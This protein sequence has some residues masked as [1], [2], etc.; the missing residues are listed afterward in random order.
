MSRKFSREVEARLD[1]ELTPKKGKQ[2]DPS[3]KKPTNSPRP[4]ASTNAPFDED[5]IFVTVPIPRKAANQ[6]LKAAGLPPGDGAE[7]IAKVS[8]FK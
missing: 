3:P 7:L 8:T 4:Q 1:G 6:L 5:R 2:Q